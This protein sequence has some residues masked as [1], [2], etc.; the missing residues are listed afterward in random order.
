MGVGGGCPVVPLPPEV[1]LGAPGG[2]L[3]AL[4]LDAEDV[5]AA[6]LLR[7]SLGGGVSLRLK[8]FPI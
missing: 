5:K 8:S 2:G 3:G 7:L 1:V 4:D 6:R